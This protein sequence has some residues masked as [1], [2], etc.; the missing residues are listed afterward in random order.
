M[1]TFDHRDTG[2]TE[3]DWLAGGLLDRVP[4][5]DL[6]DAVGHLVVLA[7]HPDDESFGAAG[8]VAH[9]ARRGTR[10]TVLVATDGEAS[11]PGSPTLSPARLA[12]VRRRELLDAVDAT[13]PGAALVF[14]GLPD[15]GVR[16]HRAELHRHLSA[17][18]AASAQDA[19]GQDAGTP[20]LLCAPWRGDG[21][22]DHRV[23]GEVA[24][25][26]AAEHGARLLEYPVWWWHWGDPWSAQ[27]PEH[28]RALALTPDDRA[29]KARAL[30]THRS[31]IGP[32][33]PDPRDAA[34][35]GT[36]MLRHADRDVEVFVEAPRYASATPV[37]RGR[38]PSSEDRRAPAQEGARTT[39][40]SLRREFFDAFYRGRSD[41]WGFETRWYEER[42]RAVT[43][44]SLPR[45]RFRAGLEIG[46]S[47]GVLTAEL[48]GRCDRMTGVDVAEA[49]LTA[50]RERLGDQVE[51]VRLDTPERWP[52]GQFDLVVLSE[53][54]YYYDAD[55]L[56]VAI[57]RAVGSLTEDGVLVACHWRHPVAEYPL[58]GDDVHA[59]LDARAGLV[60]LV[61]HLEEDFVL[62]VFSRPPGRSVA[63]E[64]GLA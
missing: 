12:T 19:H 42:K 27:G 30:A 20:V 50:A 5:L 39:S 57:S 7:A 33:S 51:L 31:Q 29:A 64:A 45:A 36:E 28:L 59:A 61:R 23:A 17:V 32:L 18:L 53:V 52:V 4:P 16:E 9:L 1:V 3:E 22:R 48:A 56:E 10:V 21:H 38:A 26:V 37:D 25:T 14:L 47:T 24:A 6:P 49:A 35:L 54:G 2:T 46:C 11:H 40:G 43:L 44:A 55:D 58:R 34:T 60:R 63:T 41:P 8:L 15:G 62:E 13:A